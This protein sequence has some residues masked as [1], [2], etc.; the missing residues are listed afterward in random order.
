M[1]E[2]R[3]LRPISEAWRDKTTAN[4]V[5]ILKDFLV[6]AEAGD[7]TGLAIV[8]TE[9][10]GSITHQVSTTEDYIRMTGALQIVL[11]RHLL[12]NPTEEVGQS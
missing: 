6:R 1:S 10:D 11:Y 5:E 12:S 3:T 8:A 2:I 4:I 9:R 7:F